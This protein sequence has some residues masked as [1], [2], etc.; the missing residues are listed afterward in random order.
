[1]TTYHDKINCRLIKSFGD[2]HNHELEQYK[3]LCAKLENTNLRA[4]Q[5]CFL[6]G[7]V[8]CG[9]V[10]LDSLLLTPFGVF[11]IEFKCY[12]NVNRIKINGQKDFLCLNADG[13]LVKTPKGDT[14]TVKGGSMDS[15]YE[16]AK[17]NRRAVRD[18]LKKCFGSDIANQIHIGLAIIFKGNVRIEGLE[19]L[20]DYDRDWLTAI[21]S[22][23]ISNYLSYICEEKKRGISI[24]Q[25]KQLIEFMDANQNVLTSTSIFDQ[26]CNLYEMG[27]YA[28]A[29]KL[30]KKCDPLNEK[31]ITKTL[32]TLFWLNDSK[33]FTSLVSKMMNNPV[34]DIRDLTYYLLGIAYQMGKCGY[35]KNDDKA[36]ECFY[37]IEKNND[38][39]T[40]RIKEIEEKKSKENIIW[41]ENNRKETTRKN[42]HSLLRDAP[43]GYD[44]TGRIVSTILFLMPFV[45]GIS[46]LLPEMKMHWHSIGTLLAVMTAAIMTFIGWKWMENYEDDCWY[47]RTSPLNHV[48]EWEFRTIKVNKRDFFEGNRWY[49][50]GL[51]ALLFMAFQI[52]PFFIGFHLLCNLVE[53]LSS[54]NLGAS[55]NNFIYN[56]SS[57]DLLKYIPWF[58]MLYF[59]LNITGYLYALVIQLTE[60]CKLQYPD[61]YKGDAYYCIAVPNL[62]VNSRPALKSSLSMCKQSLL[63]GITMPVFLSVLGA[64]KPL[65]YLLI[66]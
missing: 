40:S 3:E 50:S 24:V 59:L 43:E 4:L 9:S 26:A 66:Q 2:G 23:N 6:L 21:N 64:I 45:F 22:D 41:I 25:Q 55:F 38:Y 61:D 52:V 30:L 44:K 39:V 33:E 10:S 14:L 34:P 17:V 27:K 12:N 49:K 32:A 29:Y 35:K 65:L 58:V 51:I 13:S 63:F 1:M 18:C 19:A 5:G 28:D 46:I 48:K 57:V 42:L 54:S 47:I 36:L 60:Q 62:W 31:V 20:S 37:K 8:V 11:I 16:Q 7:N 15:P 56:N 53:W